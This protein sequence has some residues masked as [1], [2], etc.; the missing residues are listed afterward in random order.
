V[1]QKVFLIVRPET[2]RLEPYGEAAEIN[3]FKS[4]VITSMYGGSTMKYTVDIQGKNIVIDQFDPSNEGL[5]AIGQEV[6]VTIPQN[7][8]ILQK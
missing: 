8:H 1:N 3:T 6:T 4:T 7:V 5:Y 2:I